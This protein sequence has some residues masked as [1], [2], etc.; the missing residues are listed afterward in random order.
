MALGAALR[1]QRKKAPTQRPPITIS[2]PPPTKG[3]HVLHILGR[4]G[5]GGGMSGEIGGGQ[6]ETHFLCTPYPL[7]P[8]IGGSGEGGKVPRVLKGRKVSSHSP[9]AVSSHR[10][11]RWQEGME[12][13]VDRARR[14]PV[15]KGHT[16]GLGNDP[17]CSRLAQV[18]TP[19]L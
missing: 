1:P 12:N 5:A 11:R 15:I 3:I 10:W 7:A 19:N 6:M 16:G 13:L 2:P 9:P 17:M 18:T 8:Q 4:L 14:A